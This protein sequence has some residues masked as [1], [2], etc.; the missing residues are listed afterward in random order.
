M[1]ANITR[2]QSP[3]NFLMNQIL[4]CYCRSKISELCHIFKQFRVTTFLTGYLY[5]QTEHAA[6]PTHFDAVDGD[7]MF[8]RNISTRLQD[9]MS[10]LRRQQSEQSPP[11]KPR[12]L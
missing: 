9:M 6:P 5:E 1:V 4:I 11:L 12:N 7:C 8:L 10:Q 3:F 2:I